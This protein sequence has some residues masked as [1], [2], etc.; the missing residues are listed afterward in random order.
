MESSLRNI[1]CYS[2]N[3]DYETNTAFLSK[4]Q[5]LSMD[6]SGHEQEEGYVDLSDLAFRLSSKST[7]V[8]CDGGSTRHEVEAYIIDDAL[9]TCDNNEWTK[10]TVLNS[11]KAIKERDQLKTLTNMI[12]KSKIKSVEREQMEGENYY[13][14]V[15]VPDLKV[16]RGVLAPQAISVLSAAPVTI[17]KVSMNMLTKDDYAPE[18]EETVWTAWISSEDYVLRRVEGDVKFTLT[19]GSLHPPREFSDLRVETALKKSTTFSDFGKKKPL[20][21]PHEAK[22]AKDSFA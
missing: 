14:L 3:G 1:E 15:F 21:L 8:D 13:K 20:V 12:A 2:Y 10:Q 7:L 18:E 16:S 22:Y 19:A 5:S 17:P 4:C 9:Y 11:D 6:S